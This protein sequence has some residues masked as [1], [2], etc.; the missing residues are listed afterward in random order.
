MKYLL[1]IILFIPSILFGQGW[2][3]IYGGENTDKGRSV[4]QTLDG[5]Y[6]IVGYTYSFGM[7][8][9]DIYLIKIDSNGDTI[10][11]KTYGGENN[12][13]GHFV[14][15][16][17]DDGYIITGT[18]ESFGNGSTDIY[19]VKTDSNGDTLWSKTFGQ[20]HI[21]I[22]NSVQQTSDEGFIITGY[23]YF[24]G[25]SIMLLIKTDNNGDELWT[26]YYTVGDISQGYSVQQTF[27]G[28][29]IVTG[30]IKSY[31]NEYTDVYLMKTDHNGDTLWTR[32]YGGVI[33]DYGS[34]VQQTSDGGYIITGATESFGNFYSK[35]VYL[36][37]TD[38]IGDTLWTKTF[39]GDYDERGYCVQ[40]TFDEGYIITGYTVSFGH[41]L[42]DVYLIKTDNFGDT[43]WTKT[44]GGNENDQG[45]SIQQ[46][47]DFG[48]IIT[49]MTESFGTSSDIYLIKT[50]EYGIV[51]FSTE[52]PVPSPNRRLLNTIDISG[53]EIINPLKNQ[54]YIEIFDDGSVEKKMKLK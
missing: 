15:Q 11:T 18:S 10:W 14:Q 44:I 47:T 20:E 7:G 30:A 3:R 46:T 38:G 13:F 54:P 35:D 43:L 21:D 34:S 31:G 45:I 42:E 22:G 41:G 25:I 16:T 37:K 39:G 40:Q 51:T 17:T 26:K 5:G 9:A 4:Q 27:D 28:G 50:D 19:L 33:D 23:Y 2:E 6:I 52:V 12:D 8:K 32:K 36:I 48:F 1:L 24:Y 49:G 29:Y 53:K